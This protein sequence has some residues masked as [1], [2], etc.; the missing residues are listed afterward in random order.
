M[1]KLA[2][3][4]IE[5]EFEKVDIRGYSRNWGIL[6]LFESPKIGLEY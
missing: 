4:L 5:S 6:A 1:I 3:F 2:E